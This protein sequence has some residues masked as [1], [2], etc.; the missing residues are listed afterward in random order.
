MA[1]W[2]LS[3][4]KGHVVVGGEFTTETKKKHGEEAKLG[5]HRGL[6]K[7]SFQMEGGGSVWLCQIIRKVKN[8][9]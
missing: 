4:V 2:G 8:D 9:I 1:P 5:N 6:K 3:I 7:G